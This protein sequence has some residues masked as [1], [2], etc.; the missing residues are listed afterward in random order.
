[1]SENRIQFRQYSE[2]LNEFRYWG[3]VEN[4]FPDTM[5]GPSHSNS[6]TNPT[7]SEQFTGLRDKNGAKIWEGDIVQWAITRMHTYTGY[8]KNIRGVYFAWLDN[9]STPVFEL[10]DAPEGQLSVIGNIHQNPELI[11]R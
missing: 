1:M 8:V 4:E 11:T 10:C 6:W 2:S 3:F 5:I 7:K 9:R